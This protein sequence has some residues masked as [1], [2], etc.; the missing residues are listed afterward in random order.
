[1]LDKTPTNGSVAASQ[2]TTASQPT[3][4]TPIPTIA[5]SRLAHGKFTASQRAAL[6]AALELDELRV[7]RFTQT[8]AAR[9]T[10]ADR[11]YARKAR[12]VPPPVRHALIHG[13]SMVGDLH[14]YFVE[15]SKPTP[16]ASAWSSLTDAAL[17]T[18]VRDA[19]VARVWDAIVKI[20]D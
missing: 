1:V 10:R 11:A 6:A 7:E 8:Q 14:R 9:L 19:G 2:A 5:G 12:R 16:S 17:V 13:Y 18:A 3:N 15:K 4:A 20:I